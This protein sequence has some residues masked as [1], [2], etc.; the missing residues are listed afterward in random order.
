ML[1]CL[2]V[3]ERM[4]TTC[5]IASFSSQKIQSLV[6]WCILSEAEVCQS[7]SLSTKAIIAQKCIFLISPGY[8]NFQKLLPRPIKRSQISL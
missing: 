4:L 3:S 1:F 5:Y 6:R 2:S 8:N 7:G